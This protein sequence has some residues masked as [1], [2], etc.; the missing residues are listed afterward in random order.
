M[1]NLL[2]FLICLQRANRRLPSCLLPHFTPS[3]HHP[4][5]RH[6]W[7]GWRYTFNT[8]NCGFVEMWSMLLH[9]FSHQWTRIGEGVQIVPHTEFSSGP[10]SQTSSPFPQIFELKSQNHDFNSLLCEIFTNLAVKIQKS[11]NQQKNTPHKHY[12]PRT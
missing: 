10:R 5:H 11:G 6:L 1:T 12:A 2:I 4:R 3:G 9:A 8:R 7:Q